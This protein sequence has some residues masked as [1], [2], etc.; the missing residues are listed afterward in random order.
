MQIPL[1]SDLHLEFL[2]KNWPG[3]RSIEPVGGADALV[4]AGDIG[5]GSDGILLGTSGTANLQT[6]G[7]RLSLSPPPSIP[8][9]FWSGTWTG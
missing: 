5:A 2:Q 4:L 7:K 9:W 1:A 6:I 3:E 8:A